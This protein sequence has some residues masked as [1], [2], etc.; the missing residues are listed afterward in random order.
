MRKRT[1]LTKRFSVEFNQN[2]KNILKEKLIDIEIL[3]QKSHYTEKKQ[4]ELNATNK[5]NP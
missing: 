3:L 1:K 2:K 5:I 4:R